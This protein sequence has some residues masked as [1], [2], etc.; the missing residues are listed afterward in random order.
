[1]FALWA[2][3]A[4]V[5]PNR[6]QMARWDPSSGGGEHGDPGDLGGAHHGAHVVLG[7]H[8]LHGEGVGGV[9]L[10]PLVDRLGDGEQPLVHVQRWVG[11]SHPHGDQPHP[12]A[13]R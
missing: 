8:L 4:P 10:Q 6:W 12:T 1:M 2:P 11:P 13:R 5:G 7:E 3:C 9:L